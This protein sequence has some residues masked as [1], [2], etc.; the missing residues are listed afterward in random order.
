MLFENLFRGVR[1]WSVL[2]R[3]LLL[4]VA[5]S[6]TASVHAQTIVDRAGVQQAIAR[7][8]VVWDVRDARDYAKA[9]LPGAVSIGDVSRVLRDENRE[10]FISIEAIQRILAGAGL[11][12]R[13]DLV[14]YGARGSWIPY[15]ALYTTQYFGGAKTVVYHDGIEDWEAAG[16][17]VSRAAHVLAPIALTLAVD[18]RRAIETK[19]LIARLNRAD[20]QIV[21]VRTPKEFAGEDIRALRGGHVPG[22]IN[23]P[24]EHNWVDPDTPLKLARKLVGDT[25]GMSLKPTDELRKLYAKLDPAKET[26]VYCQSGAR[27]SETAGV[28]QQLGFS[29][30]RVYDASWLGYANT[31]DAPA[32]AVTFVNIGALNNRIGALQ[33][34][35]EHLERELAEARKARP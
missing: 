7:G 32:E 3:G 6:A 22:A 21:D 34:R 28:L 29:N 10:D 14:V 23:I 27:A 19:E 30:V 33:S 12:P 20:V 11:D 8:A 4:S 15:F 31:L 9:H 16:L 25:R 2:A 5:L 13:A 24:Y 17:P 26:I 18:A 1:A 35:V